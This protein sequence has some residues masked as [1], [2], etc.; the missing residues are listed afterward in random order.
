MDARQEVERAERLLAT[1]DPLS[2]LL[3]AQ[4]LEQL[5]SKVAVLRDEN[6]QAAAEI[7]AVLPRGWQ[8]I[9]H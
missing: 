6:P 4:A 3:A 9:P 2:I 5:R 1:G 8:R 7:E